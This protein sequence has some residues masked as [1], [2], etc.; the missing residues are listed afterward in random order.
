MGYFGLAFLK[1]TRNPGFLEPFEKLKNFCVPNYNRIINGN[2]T[3]TALKFLDDAIINKSF[4][5]YLLLFATI[6]IGM[7]YLTSNLIDWRKC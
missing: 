7:G 4:S 1:L 3:G 6:K 5:K 2:T